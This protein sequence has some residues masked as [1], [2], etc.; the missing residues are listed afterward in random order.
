MLEY[1]RERTKTTSPIKFSLFRE[2]PL[3]D[4]AAGVGARA[5]AFA[6]AK[7]GEVMCIM[8]LNRPGLQE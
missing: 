8:M 1:K 6:G 5:V 4:G 2:G 3:C 7:V